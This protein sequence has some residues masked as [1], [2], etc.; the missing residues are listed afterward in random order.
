MPNNGESLSPVG[1]KGLE[2]GDT[3][4]T[5]TKQVETNI[6]H[7]KDDGIDLAKYQL[8]NNFELK[9]KEV[10][11]RTN[12]G[13]FHIPLKMFK[14]YI[15]NESLLIQQQFPHT[16]TQYLQ[17]D[18]YYPIDHNKFDENSA[19]RET[20]KK[21]REFLESKGLVPENYLRQHGGANE[22]TVQLISVLPKELL[23]EIMFQGLDYHFSS[24]AALEDM[25]FF[26][27]RL[28]ASSSSQF[29]GHPFMGGFEAS[30]EWQEKTKKKRR[31][32]ILSK[33]WQQQGLILFLDRENWNS[34]IRQYWGD[35]KE[36]L[37]KWGKQVRQ[38]LRPLYESVSDGSVPYEDIDYVR[39]V[40]K[41]VKYNKQMEATPR[42]V[43]LEFLYNKKVVASVSNPDMLKY[44]KFQKGDFRLAD[45]LEDET[46]K[47]KSIEITTKGFEHTLKFAETEIPDWYNSYLERISENHENV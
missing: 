34:D 32:R 38:K 6:E 36:P 28:I 43:R 46:G 21:C 1:L 22:K 45:T 9:E 33:K 19:H 18:R 8:P 4:L 30:A 2:D 14:L 24:H 5:K 15:L 23:D 17:G 11:V 44:M 39:L 7:S 10:L 40:L 31:E 13:V 20:R 27:H 47:K 41:P 35:Y 26:E 29:F 25:T 3:T 12:A 37:Q 42:P 16:I